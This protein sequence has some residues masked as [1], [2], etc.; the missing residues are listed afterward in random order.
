MVLI[1]MVVGLVLCGI[2]N[3]RAET[4]CLPGIKEAPV[5]VTNPTTKPAL[6]T[7]VVKVSSSPC[8]YRFVGFSSAPTTG[9]AG[10]PLGLDAL[11]RPD[12]G[13]HARAC[14]IREYLLTHS[15][16]TVIPSQGA[17][18]NP[19]SFVAIYHSDFS[20]VYLIEQTTA[21]MSPYLTDFNCSYWK[22]SGPGANG[23]HLIPGGTYGLAPCDW[24]VPVACCAY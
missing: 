13:T 4:P 17:W 10:G 11:C 23:M 16:T 7:G 18:L 21:M 8:C 3:V 9:D 15:S 20:K 22:S 14:T 5:E 12:Y 19:D 1:A 2:G 6:V 24:V